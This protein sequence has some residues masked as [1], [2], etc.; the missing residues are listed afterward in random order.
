MEFMCLLFEQYVIYSLCLEHHKNDS[1]DFLNLMLYLFSRHC[2]GFHVVTGCCLS[3]A[4]RDRCHRINVSQENTEQNSAQQQG[5]VV[6]CYKGNVWKV[7]LSSVQKI[8][9]LLSQ[10]LFV[11]F[12]SLRVCN[13]QVLN[14][15]SVEH[16]LKRFYLAI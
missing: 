6:F 4:G 10:N 16:D 3:H 12:E 2:C 9:I 5:I 13:V 11:R 14:L 1:I 8:R 15:V 7:I